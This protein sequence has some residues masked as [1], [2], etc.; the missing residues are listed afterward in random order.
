MKTLVMIAGAGL[1]FM[2]I[3][4]MAA[5]KVLKWKEDTAKLRPLTRQIF[6]TYMNYIFVTNLCIGLLSLCAPELLLRDD[7][8]TTLVA[9]YIFVYWG[10]R[11]VLQFTYMD[12]SDKPPG[13]F[14]KFCEYGFN[15]LF[16][17]FAMVY[18]YLFIGK[19]V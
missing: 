14:F 1:L 17:Y 2:V 5:P 6:W 10:A 18:G 19:L 4:T 7:P 13:L 9:G 15:T 11:L 3:A 8:L 12:K 16:V